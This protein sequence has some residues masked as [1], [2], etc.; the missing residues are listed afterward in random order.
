MKTRRFFAGV[1]LQENCKTF[2]VSLLYSPLRLAVTN[3]AMDLSPVLLGILFTLVLLCFVI[4]AKVYCS[5][6]S[7][8]AES[9]LHN[10]TKNMGNINYKHDAVK[11]SEMVCFCD[12]TNLRAFE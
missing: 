9:S 10:E 1:E 12:K 4:I 3:A 2:L 8:T 5:R 11:V 6:S 7:T